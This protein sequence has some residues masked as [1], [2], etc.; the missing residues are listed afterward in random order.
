MASTVT[1][2]RVRLDV[3]G[4]VAVPPVYF[5]LT[6]V[7]GGVGTV[8]IPVAELV[9]HAETATLAFDDD[10]TLPLRIVGDSVLLAD[11]DSAMIEGWMQSGV[12]QL[13]KPLTAVNTDLCALVIGYSVLLDNVVRM[14]GPLRLEYSCRGGRGERSGASGGNVVVTNPSGPS[15]PSTVSGQYHTGKN[16]SPVSFDGS[17]FLADTGT[18]TDTE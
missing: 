10:S 13:L 15:A 18:G 8:H 7:W 5:M 17:Q 12:V 1:D 2:G 4:S 6:G 3:H 11:I 16:N 9:G 14:R